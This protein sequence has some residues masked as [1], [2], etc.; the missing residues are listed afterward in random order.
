MKKIDKLVLKSFFGP[1]LL[2][3]AVVEFI[4]LSQTLIKY[5]EDLVGKDLGLVVYLKLVMYFCVN[6]VPV[7]LPLGI[8]LSSIM[9]FG[10]LGEHKELTALKS[11]GISLIRLLAPVFILVIGMSAGLFYFTEYAVTR[12]NLEVYS[13]LYD[14]RQ[15][16]P[17]LDFK[18][19]IFYAGIPGYSIKIDKKFDDGKTLKD[20][21]IYD[22]TKKKGNTDVILAD[23]GI[24]YMIKDNRYLVLELYKGRRYAEYNDASKSKKMRYMRSKFEKSK[25]VFSMASFAMEDTKKDLFKS[26]K[27]MMVKDSLA[28]RYISIKGSKQ[29]L[30]KTLPAKSDNFFKYYSV[31]SSDSV[32]K[33]K[34]EPVA[35][36]DSFVAVASRRK[37][38]SLSV[39]RESMRKARNTVSFAGTNIFR[40]NH[41]DR[42]ANGYRIEFLKRYAQPF[43]CLILFLI[44]APLGAII[45]KGGMGI[46]VIISILFFIV[47]YVSSEI[48]WKMARD[49]VV[50][51]E[52]GVWF[53]NL[54]LIPVGLYF[55]NQAR[56]DS[57]LLE[58][59]HWKRFFQKA[60]KVHEYD[61]MMKILNKVNDKV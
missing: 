58:S 48:G 13:L 41:K 35:K 14:V 44:G 18:E 9:T 31:N 40:L 36:L 25:L 29:V 30:V 60:W 19:K 52:I 54:I 33:P 5:F 17:T 38:P 46:P 3:F 24:M 7:A 27:I 61:F 37:E 2:T 49:G 4:F 1:F 51:I 57:N 42:E 28:F 50:G 20:L 8:L 6:I 22:H 32:P 53:A 11:A 34:M 10:N 15:M 12:A 55:L 47:L 59:D 56:K 21:I 16:K 45:K 43:S 26:H 23:S 39:V